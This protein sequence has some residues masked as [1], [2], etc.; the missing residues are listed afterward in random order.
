[1]EDI[2]TTL[3]FKKYVIRWIILICFICCFNAAKSSAATDYWPTEGWRASAPEKQGMQ[4]GMLSDM[5]ENVKERGYGIESITIIRNGYKVTDAYFHPFEKGTKHILHSCT[6]S[7]TSALVGIALD[8]GHI[9]NV[10]QP[11]LEFFPERTIASVHPRMDKYLILGHKMPKKS[12]F[13]VV[14]FP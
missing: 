14:L 1:M 8:K 9:K 10:N 5:L 11:I 12:H 2:M 3:R 6:K 13:K 4:S 7:I